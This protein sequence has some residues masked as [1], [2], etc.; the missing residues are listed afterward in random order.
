MAA[1]QVLF[2]LKCAHKRIAPLLRV[3]EKRCK[4]TGYNF[5]R[6]IIDC[7]NFFARNLRH[8]RQYYRL[9]YLEIQ[10]IHT[11]L[12]DDSFDGIFPCLY[13]L[14]SIGDILPPMALDGS[15]AKMN[16]LK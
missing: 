9:I 8:L 5:N 11:Q 6:Q 4:G 14:S 12:L 13:M 3:S 2:F 16:I 10:V 7:R 15:Q 1:L